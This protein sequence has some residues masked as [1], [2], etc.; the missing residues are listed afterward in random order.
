[1]AVAHK[2]RRYGVMVVQRRGLSP[3]AVRI[4][5]TSPLTACVRTRRGAFGHA[6]KTGSPRQEPLSVLR[7]PE[8]GGTDCGSRTT[9]HEPLVPKARVPEVRG[10]RDSPTG[11]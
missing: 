5:P 10:P 11:C 1:M 9:N 3:T 4:A 8:H 6:E 2:V 7:G